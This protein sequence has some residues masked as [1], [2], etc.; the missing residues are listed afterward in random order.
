MTESTPLSGKLF[1]M[2]PPLLKPLTS[3]KTENNLKE[4]IN[5]FQQTQG[6]ITNHILTNHLC[7]YVPTTAVAG[8]PLLLLCLWVPSRIKGRHTRSG[9]RPLRN[10]R[11][12]LLLTPSLRLFIVLP[13][14]QHH[15]ADRY[16]YATV[17]YTNC[18][19]IHHI[20]FFFRCRAQ[21]CWRHHSIGVQLAVTTRWNQQVSCSLSAILPQYQAHTVAVGVHRPWTCHGWYEDDELWPPLILASDDCIL[22]FVFNSFYVTWLHSFRRMHVTDRY[23]VTPAKNNSC[24]TKR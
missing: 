4:R 2:L 22:V 17:Q 20:D 9:Y 24:G 6:Q 16:G 14:P 19:S 3:G 18:I 13:S 15:P 7:C 21:P 10:S 1:T 5:V 8:W 11:E 12:M 23:D